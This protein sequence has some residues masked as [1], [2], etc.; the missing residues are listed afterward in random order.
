ML[1]QMDV[2]SALLTL[3]RLEGRFLSQWSMS[4]PWAVDGAAEGRALF[5]YALEGRI[6]VQADDGETVS[7]EPGDM[8]L[9]P[10]GAAQ[11]IGN[12]LERTGVPIGQFL[13]ASGFEGY[14]QAGGSAGATT[15]RLLYAGMNYDVMQ[16]MP[17]CQ[18]F[19]SVLVVKAAAIDEEPML[20]HGLRGL[21]AQAERSAPGHNPIL[22]RAIE[23]IYTLGLSLALTGSGRGSGRISQA[24]RDPRIA[25][26]LYFM[27]TNFRE[28]WSIDDLAARVG[29]SKS[30]LS[31]RFR[32]LVGEPPARHLARIR[33][34]EASQLLRTTDLSQDAVAQHVGYGTTVGMHLAFRSILG[35]APGA[36]RKRGDSA[37]SA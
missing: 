28:K 10:H 18:L 26:C 31:S 24:L 33:V 20:L 35:E 23:L 14:S 27:Y 9:F 37:S 8:A 29:M 4:G 17:L 15:S 16:A 6:D 32:E 3:V 19:P 22:L 7:L 21:H 12:A 11:R 34:A 30:A 25:R 36:V 5:V 1:E 2:L 13:P